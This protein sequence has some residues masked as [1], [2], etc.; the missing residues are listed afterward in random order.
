MSGQGRT[1]SLAPGTSNI[2]S[3]EFDPWMCWGDDQ[4]P[5]LFL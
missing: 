1:V 4:W 5:E 3:T 2:I